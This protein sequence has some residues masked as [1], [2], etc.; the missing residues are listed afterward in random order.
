[1]K[2][3]LDRIGLISKKSR[4]VNPAAFIIPL[5]KESVSEIEINRDFY[6]QG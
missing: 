4:R 2:E 1:M 3:C 6:T 5:L